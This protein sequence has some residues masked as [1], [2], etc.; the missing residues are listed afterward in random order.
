MQLVWERRGT[1]IIR[2]IIR[3]MSMI[4]V[5][6][7]IV[8][9][10]RPF[11]NP[12]QNWWAPRQN[13]TRKRTLGE[14]SFKKSLRWEVKEPERDLTKQGWIQEKTLS[15]LRITTCQRSWF[16]KNLIASEREVIPIWQVRQMALGL[17]VI[18]IFQFRLSSNIA[19]RFNNTSNSHNIFLSLFALS[20]FF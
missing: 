5:K 17:R 3:R 16:V 18:H 4:G 14:S 19:E 7:T 9:K 6:I 13:L 11:T 2:Q 1:W 10:K 20:I 15:L 8:E 12:N